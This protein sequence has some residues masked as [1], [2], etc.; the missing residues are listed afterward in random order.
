MG[1]LQ[2]TTLP[3]VTTNPSITITIMKTNRRSKLKYPLNKPTKEKIT[4][5]TK[6]IIN[7]ISTSLHGFMLCV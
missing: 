1:T 5:L 4:K 6:L 7:K 3:H 2:G